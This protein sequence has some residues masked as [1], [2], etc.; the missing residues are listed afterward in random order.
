MVGENEAAFAEVP[1]GASRNRKRLQVKELA[2]SG[3][4]ERVK[5]VVERVKLFCTY[6]SDQRK[7]GIESALG[8]HSLALPTRITELATKVR[9]W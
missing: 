9:G 7:F 5:K 3:H 6:D 2:K 8:L 4:V 1:E